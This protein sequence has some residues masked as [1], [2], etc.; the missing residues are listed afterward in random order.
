MPWSEVL[1]IR[2]ALP[3]GSIE[4]VLLELHALGRSREY[5]CVPLLFT[6]PT[7]QQKRRWPNHRMLGAHAHESYLHLA[8]FKPASMLETTA[9]G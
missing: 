1:H 6:R 5:A 3:W 8:D 9:S 7:D 4:R 2:D